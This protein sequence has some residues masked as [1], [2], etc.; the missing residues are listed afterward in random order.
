MAFKKYPK[1]IGV[2]DAVI[3]PYAK[4][5][6]KQV[7]DTG[8][9]SYGPMSKE[10]ERQFAEI[11]QRKF[12][13]VTNSG[14][15]ALQVA[16]HALKIKHKWSKDSEVIVPALTFVATVNIVL[17]NGLKPVFVDVDPQTYNI[18]P[19]KI[20]SKISKKTKA[21]I[22]VDL[23]G[24]PC[25]IDKVK[26]IAKKYKLKI[27]QDSCENM[28]T[29]YNN[30]PVGYFSDIAC[31]ST[32]VA[33]MIT[34]GVG[35]LITTNDEEL[36]VLSRSLVNHGRDNIYIS[37][38]DD[39]NKKG[40]GLAEVMGR[41]FSFIHQGYSY[42]I[43]EMEAALGIAELK[44][45][46]ANL[47]KRKANGRKLISGLKPFKDY[48]QV[49]SWPKKAEHGFMMFPIVVT[50][51]KIKREDLTLFLE[52]HNVETRPLMPLLNQPIYKKLFGNLEPKYPVATHLRKNAFYIGS[53]HGLTKKELNYIIKVF[54]EY[55]KS[56]R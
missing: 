4:K 19:L 18:D 51:K 53:H 10:F 31:H 56:I 30:R 43:T 54:K 14:T 9:L 41:R 45:W 55:F 2:G 12:A 44:T 34:T 17:A 28:F 40:K 38:D 24:L 39:K 13:I 36:A 48:I 37:I 47:R 26:K 33:H 1:Q 6:V 7:L 15:S 11:H 16:L 25:E 27:L 46:R 52:E 3:S 5:L 50:N 20:E 29:K 23:C 21:I 8:R 32:Y 22:P 42:R 35:G 49:S